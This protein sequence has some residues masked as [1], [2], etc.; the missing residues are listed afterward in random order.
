MTKIDPDEIEYHMSNREKSHK[1]SKQ[2]YWCDKCD[3]D[4]VGDFGKCKT[5][6]YKSSNKRKDKI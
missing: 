2:L 6:G 1:A 4:L 3:A 5:C